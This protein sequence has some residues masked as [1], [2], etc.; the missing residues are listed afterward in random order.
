MLFAATVP[1]VFSQVAATSAIDAAWNTARYSNPEVDDLI[2]QA[3]VEVDLDARAELY[4]QIQE[5]LLADMPY[6][7]F[8]VIQN[9][10]VVN[11]RLQ[12]FKADSNA[13]LDFYDAYVVE[14]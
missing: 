9:P 4:Y 2:A 3:A 10:Y 1:N 12:N 7:P 11:S 5:I 13:F 6:V 8:Y 14:D